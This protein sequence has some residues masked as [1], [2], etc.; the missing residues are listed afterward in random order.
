[1]GVTVFIYTENPYTYK[2]DITH[3][4]TAPLFLEIFLSNQ[5]R[6]WE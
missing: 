6:I 2:H 1:M 3:E 4:T 5:I